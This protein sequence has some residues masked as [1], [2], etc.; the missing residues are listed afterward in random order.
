M[1][2]CLKFVAKAVNQHQLS[3]LYM[4]EVMPDPGN[5]KTDKIPALKVQSKMV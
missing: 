5:T 3:A 4:S 1:T 2:Q